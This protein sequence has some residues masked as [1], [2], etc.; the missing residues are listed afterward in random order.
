VARHSLI[1]HLQHVGR[2][3]PV[4]L[5]DV[6]DE[7]RSLALLHF[8][9]SLKTLDA[10]TLSDLTEAC[11][12]GSQPQALDWPQVRMLEDSGLI[13]FGPHGASHAILTGLDDQRLHEE[14]TRSWTALENGCAQPLP[15]YCYPNGDHDARVR[16]QVA[17]HGFPF[18]LGTEAGLYR[19]D[20]D[21]LNLPRFGVSQRN[22]RHPELLAWRIRRGARP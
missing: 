9:Q 13:R 2:P 15:V 1:E 22:A 17:A 8:L 10:R 12:Q 16:Q 6:D 20:G 7:R 21:P 11:P 3:L 18:A 14:L 5:D 4:L 19:H